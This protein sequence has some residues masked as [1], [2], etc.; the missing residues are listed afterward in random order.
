MQ[1]IYPIGTPGK[2]WGNEEKAQWKAQQSVKRS[3]QEEVLDKLSKIVP[4][5]FQNRIYLD[6][7]LKKANIGDVVSTGD[8]TKNLM[9][10]QVSLAGKGTYFACENDEN[11][12]IKFDKLTKK[13]SCAAVLTLTEPYQIDSLNIDL[14]YTYKVRATIGPI[15]FEESLEGLI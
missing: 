6:I 15:L 14:D 8:Y 4:E 1:Q 3:Y 11:G 10:I 12:K 5:G 7:Y 9:D 13:V 2:P